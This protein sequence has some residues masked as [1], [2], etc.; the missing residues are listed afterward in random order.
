MARTSRLTGAG[1]IFKQLAR[2]LA[3]P[4]EAGDAPVGDLLPTEDELAKRHGVSRHTV[5]HA[6]ANCARSD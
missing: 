5:R 6:L 1:P 4:I 3:E 2:R